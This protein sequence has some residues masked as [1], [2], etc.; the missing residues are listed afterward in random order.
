MDG[1]LEFYFDFISPF[2]YLASLRVDEM[3][4]A[5]G[6]ETRWRSMLL[7]VS[8]LKVMGMKPL[9][10]TPLKGPYL[11]RDL[12][13]YLRRH[14]LTLGRDLD[15]PPANPLPAGRAF[16]A[17]DAQDPVLAKRV[18]QALLHA[19]WIED[20]N[21]GQPEVTASIAGSAGA[22]AGRMIDAISGGEG[23]RR[24][25]VAVDASLSKGVF[26]FAVFPGGRRALFRFGEDGVAR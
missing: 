12:A 22:D 9:P 14:G 18:A 10:Q 25:R 4:R 7:G 20:R 3:A 17:L 2:G 11:R 6:W 13:R 15:R 23:D 21:I 1:P 5:H 19:Y 26:W 8:V 16:H 24:L